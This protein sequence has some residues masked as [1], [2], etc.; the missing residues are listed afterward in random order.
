MTTEQRKA[1]I[2]FVLHSMEVSGTCDQ[3]IGTTQLIDTM[4]FFLELVKLW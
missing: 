3:S 1:I 2:Y 4:M